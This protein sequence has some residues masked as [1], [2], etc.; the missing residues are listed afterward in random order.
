MLPGAESHK[1][2][3][4]ELDKGEALSPCSQQTL[5]QRAPQQHWESLQR[6]ALRCEALTGSCGT[7]IIPTFQREELR[8]M[9]VD[10]LAQGPIHQLLGAAHRDLFC[11]MGSETT[12]QLLLSP[13]PPLSPQSSEK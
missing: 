13:P 1:E 11:S 9:G 2:A 10:C 8:L 12:Q 5:P 6:G 7:R 4:P 3:G